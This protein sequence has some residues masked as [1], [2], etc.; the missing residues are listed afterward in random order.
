MANH[1]RLACKAMDFVGCAH[2]F[3]PQNCRILIL[4]WIRLFHRQITSENPFARSQ[5]SWKS[6]NKHHSY[7]WN[8]G[9]WNPQFLSASTHVLPT[10]NMV[11]Q[12]LQATNPHLCNGSV[13]EMTV[14]MVNAVLCNNNEELFCKTR[15]APKFRNLWFSYA[16]ETAES[17]VTTIFMISHKG[18]N[19]IYCVLRFCHGNDC[20][21]ALRILLCSICQPEPPNSKHTLTQCLSY[22]LSW[23]GNGKKTSHLCITYSCSILQHFQ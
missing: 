4:S 23:Y 14:N 7:K 8:T 3:C 9:T 22:V 2:T 18:R 12:M 21:R 15:Y 11:V 5:S 17:T 19:W 20:K 16:S 10:H 1:S 13:M 6:A